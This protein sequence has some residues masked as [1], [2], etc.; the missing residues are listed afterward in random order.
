MVA[1]SNAARRRARRRFGSTGASGA[2]DAVDSTAASSPA[3]SSDVRSRPWLRRVALGA[4]AVG[5]VAAVVVPLAAQAGGLD[6]VSGIRDVLIG[7]ESIGTDHETSPSASSTASTSTAPDTG[8]EGV[9]ISIAPTV[10]TTFTPGAPGSAVAVSVE[11]ENLSGSFVEAGTL[12]LVRAGAP[13]DTTDDL[14]AWLSGAGA[15]S[16]FGS[17][18]VSLGESPTRS[19]G[20][21]GVTELAFT[22]P[23]EA[24]ADVADSPVI[25]LGAEFRVGDLVISTQ[26]SALANTASTAVGTAPVALVAPI[27]VPSAASGIISSE[28]L[29]EW[30]APTG[31]LTRQLDALAGRQIAIGIDPRII[32]SIRS[33]GASAPQE[34]LDWLQR[35]ADVSNETFPLAYADAD[36]ALQSQIGL[37]AP[38][39]P[40]SF[41]DVLDPDDFV[42]DAA[43]DDSADGDS[44]DVDG[45][46][47]DVDA[48]GSATSAPSPTPTPTEPVSPVPTTDELLDWSYTRA[49]IAWPGDDTVAPGDIAFFNAA[50]LT[51]TILDSSNLEPVDTARASA[52]VD[53]G[54]AIVADDDLTT[55]VRAAAAATSDL[56]W[57]DATS[58]VLARST[59]D[60]A[61][62]S[63]IPLLAT[64]DRDY[65]Q[66]SERVADLLGE[67]ANSP[68]V[69]PTGLAQ[70]IGSPPA[71]RT[72][73][74]GQ[75]DDARRTLASRMVSAET[76]VDAF[77]TVLDDPQT[78]TGPTRRD[79]LALYDVGWLASPADWT[80]SATDWLTAQREL[81]HSVSVVP[82]STV[83]VVASATGIPIT[84][85]NTSAYAITVQVDVAPSNGR[86]V[87]DEPVQVTVEPGSRNTVSVPVAAGVGNGEVLL[88][89]SLQS[90]TGVS[91][92]STVVIQADVQADWEGL[93]A[94]ALATVLVVIFGIG[95]WR[96]IRRR[97]RQR[98]AEAAPSPQGDE[99]EADAA[100]ENASTD[101]D[102]DAAGTEP[103]RSARADEPDTDT[104]PS[105]RTDD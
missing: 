62:D 16:G 41:V 71:A 105:E 9:D 54:T 104:S 102:A 92:G 76:D 30:T 4:G 75:E 55:A 60:G 50:G 37:P 1:D 31:L 11:L 87:V 15:T 10:S 40:E 103:E 13:I 67:L 49:D 70:V 98:A 63:S 34:A 36:L 84:V 96:N 74:D 77:A 73:I 78:L 3:S 47:A 59:L 33:L 72:L 32:A 46:S 83:L 24:F 6:A 27:T 23:A 68:F 21:G 19:L 2:H 28:E 88:M 95:I 42:P 17:D 100:H 69:T 90:L 85:Q 65:G 5:V 45:D 89:V 12:E 39:A 20:A 26:T 61:E 38:L 22:I 56:E 57:R 94:A 97:R 44:A 48:D 99:T 25:G 7:A 58:E 51:T 91:V 82:S 35:L 101:A 86:L 14:D 79:L 81:V 64:F 80:G 52:L 43:A 93:G 8:A 66:G 29:A 53:G 18:T